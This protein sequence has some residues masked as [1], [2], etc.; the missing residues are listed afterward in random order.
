LGGGHPYSPA[1]YLPILPWATGFL[2]ISEY[3][4]QLWS[5]EP[6]GKRSN[7]LQVVYAGVDT[8]RFSPAAS[9][10]GA[11]RGEVLYVGR[12]LPHKGI[13]F[14]IDAIEPPLSLRIVGRPYDEPYL[15]MLRERAAGK[16]VTFESDVDDAALADRYRA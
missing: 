10:S 7:R 13:E 11:P 6:A 16:P 15:A 14:L 2:L 1:L 4:R 9:S 3:S 8:T 5:R 12:I